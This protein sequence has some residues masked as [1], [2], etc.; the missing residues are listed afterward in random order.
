MT[1]KMTWF[2]GCQQKVSQAI[3]CQWLKDELRLTP[4]LTALKGRWC[5]D[6]QHYN[7]QHS[8]AQLIP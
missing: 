8:S 2:T 7:S 3:G 6:M 4:S 1:G 5:Q